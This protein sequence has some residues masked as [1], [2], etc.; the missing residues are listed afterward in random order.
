MTARFKLFFKRICFF[1]NFEPCHR[2]GN[3][4][5]LVIQ[6]LRENEINRITARIFLKLL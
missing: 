2:S 6:L 5:M 4:K 1:I 3:T